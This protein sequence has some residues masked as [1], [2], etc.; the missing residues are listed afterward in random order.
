MIEQRVSDERVA[1]MLDNKTLCACD[2]GA[3][4]RVL[5]DLRELR[6]EFAAARGAIEARDALLAMTVARLGGNVEGA[7]TARHNFLQRI[8]ALRDA[9][10]GFRVVW[11]LRELYNRCIDDAALQ[12]GAPP[13]ERFIEFI[14][15]YLQHSRGMK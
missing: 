3:V 12:G 15:L 14:E 9:E 6:A 1:L 4:E 11:V 10:R 5:L 7:P 13:V 2:Y 8:D